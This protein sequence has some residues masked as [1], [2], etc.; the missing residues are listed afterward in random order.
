MMKNNLYEAELYCR[1]NKY[2]FTKPRKLVLQ[3]I[4]ENKNAIGAYN[5]IKVI[6]IKQEIKPATVYRA[7]KFWHENDFIHRVESLNGYILC[8]LRNR[9][10]GTQIIIC[11][12][13]KMTKETNLISLNISDKI[14]EQESFL[15][16]FCNVEIHGI[17]NECQQQKITSN[18]QTR[19]LL[20]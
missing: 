16:N 1:K 12:K 7:I 19:D 3:T 5:I 6:S 15:I 4:I 8:S 2:R 10:K 18:H 13:C 17:C 20:R 14:I 11:N 9:H